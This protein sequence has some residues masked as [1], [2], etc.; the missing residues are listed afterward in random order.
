MR[1]DFVRLAEPYRASLTTAKFRVHKKSNQRVHGNGLLLKH[2]KC[3]NHCDR[4]PCATTRC[5]DVRNVTR[6]EKSPGA[7]APGL[8]QRIAIQ[9]FR[10]ERATGLE[11]TTSS[12]GSRGLTMRT[13]YSRYGQALP[14]RE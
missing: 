2:V 10:E 1:F 8:F 4:F 7:I 11:P 13:R 9:R 14:E 12:L 3:V 6:N 5:D